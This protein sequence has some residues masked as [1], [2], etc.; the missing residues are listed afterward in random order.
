MDPRR[1]KLVI[2]V[3]AGGV[4]KTTLAAAMAL[5]SGNSG[6]D[7]LVMTFDPSLR[8]KDSLGVGDE[9]RGE[10]T[11]VGTGKPSR[12]WASLLDARITFDPSPA[13]QAIVDSWPADV[14][15]SRARRDWGLD[16]RHGMREA[17]A[18]YLVPALR[19]RYAGSGPNR[20]SRRSDKSASTSAADPLR[21]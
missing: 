6:K 10:E 16:P 11:P 7:T 21:S 19:R 13:A 15:D 9:A 5:A 14:D 4:G 20:D 17:L 8:L 12:L 18:D 2:V 3:G 1:S